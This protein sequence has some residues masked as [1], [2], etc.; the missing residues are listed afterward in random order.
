MGQGSL[1]I[2]LIGVRTVLFGSEEST[3]PSTS[4]LQELMMVLVSPKTS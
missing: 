2:H 4:S 1:D 3:V